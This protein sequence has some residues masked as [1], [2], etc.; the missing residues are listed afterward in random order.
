[1]QPTRL[2]DRC[3]PVADLAMHRA[4]SYRDG[5]AAGSRHRV[6]SVGMMS[7]VEL[8]RRRKGQ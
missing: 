1:M 7:H 6:N 4:T 3:L 2:S 8:L 5:D